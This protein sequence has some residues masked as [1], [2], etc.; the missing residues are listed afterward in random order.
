MKALLQKLRDD[1]AGMPAQYIGHPQRQYVNRDA[2]LAIMDARIAALPTGE[3]DVALVEQLNALHV[4]PQFVA[5]EHADV[6]TPRQI[7]GLYQVGNTSHEAADRIEALAAE[8]ATLKAERDAGVA[9]LALRIEAAM[10]KPI[11]GEWFNS[12]VNGHE[13]INK[14]ETQFMRMNEVNRVLEVMK[15]NVRAALTDPANNRSA[16]EDEA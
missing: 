11:N 10:A 12:T 1:V 7:K 2:L 16:G 8:N 3:G 9:L 6:L 13:V 15:S 4:W 14:G 5:D